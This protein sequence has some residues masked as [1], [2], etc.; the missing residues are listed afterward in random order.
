[1]CNKFKIGGTEIK[2]SHETKQEKKAYL[3][4]AQYDSG[5]LL[6]KEVKESLKE[7]H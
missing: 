7:E 5:F 3:F 4:C 1:V 6:Y 2:S